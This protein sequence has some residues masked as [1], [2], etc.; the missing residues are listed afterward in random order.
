MRTVVLSHRAQEAL[1]AAVKQYPRVEELYLGVEWSLARNPELGGTRVS[2]TLPI[3]IMIVRSWVKT[4][5][6]EVLFRFD[7]DPNQVHILSIKI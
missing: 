6:L 5:D 7:E 2:K 1:D 4:P 3:F